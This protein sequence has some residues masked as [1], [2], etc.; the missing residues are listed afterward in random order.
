MSPPKTTDPELIRSWLRGEP[1]FLDSIGISCGLLETG[2]PGDLMELDAEFHADPYAALR[3]YKARDQVADGTADAAWC[4]RLGR[5]IGRFGVTHD[6]AVDIL[7]DTLSRYLRTHDPERSAV[8]LRAGAILKVKEQLAEAVC[9]LI[10]AEQDF[11]SDG[12]RDVSGPPQNLLG[13]FTATADLSGGL[14]LE[15]AFFIHL[16]S[17]VPFGTAMRQSVTEFRVA[18][19]IRENPEAPF[20]FLIRRYDIDAALPLSELSGREA[21]VR[22]GFT[23]PSF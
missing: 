6:R 23:E 18:Q 21:I 5:D 11:I 14:C 7:A 9:G 22:L 13:S 19:A 4:A 16:M 1:A 2:D 10:D 3:L 17:S 8:L 15:R 12:P 20:A